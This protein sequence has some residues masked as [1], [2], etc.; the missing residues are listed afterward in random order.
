MSE[1]R[2]EILPVMFKVVD[3]MKA[4]VETLYYR[5]QLTKSPPPKDSD[6]FFVE[7]I[8]GQKKINGEVNYLVKYL[9][10]PSKFN[11][12]VPKS[13]LKS[14]DSSSSSS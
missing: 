4:P 13:N 8:L 9:Y 11:Q 6:Y 1:I 7:K 10:Y 3:L 2:A 5:E 14:K 12:Y